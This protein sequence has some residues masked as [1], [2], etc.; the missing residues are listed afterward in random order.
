TSRRKPHAPARA[1]PHTS[2]GIAAHTR[3]YDATDKDCSP[4]GFSC[5]PILLPTLPE[6]IQ[7]P[8]PLPPSDPHRVRPVPQTPVPH[9]IHPV[10]PRVV[11]P[12]QQ[13][14]PHRIEVLWAFV[15]RD[16]QRPVVPVGP[17]VN[18]LRRVIVRM[19]H[20]RCRHIRTFPPAR[21]VP[22]RELMVLRVTH[23]F[24]K[25][26]LAPNVLAHPA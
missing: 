15:P 25:R 12:A 10:T 24:Q 20:H 13:Q 16:R 2:A 1:T 6:P 23:R 7:P 17:L 26:P 3:R 21:L 9:A 8:P 22:R 14:R 11:H 4:R 18:L 5:R 19:H